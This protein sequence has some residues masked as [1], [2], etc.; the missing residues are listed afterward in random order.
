MKKIILYIGIPIILPFFITSCQKEIILFPFF[1]ND[2][3][4]YL[5]KN[6]KA[7]IAPQYSRSR[8][9]SESFAAVRIGNKW[10]FINDEFTPVI[11]NKYWLVGDFFNGRA[12]VLD[13]DE[14]WT[15]ITSEGKQLS[16]Q[17]FEYVG[18][19]HENFAAVMIDGK[20]GFIDRS[21]KM[22]IS[23]QFS[24]AWPFS[25][26]LAAVNKNGRWF[27]INTDGEPVI[28]NGKFQKVIIENVEDLKS[29]DT[30]TFDDI[31]PFAEGRSRVLIDNQW[32][33][34]D[35]S[36]EMIIPPV[37]RRAQDFSEGLAPVFQDEWFFINPDGEKILI[38]DFN[39][40]WVYPFSEGLAGV[41]LGELFGYINRKGE[42]VI[43]GLFTWAGPFKNGIALVELEGWWGYINKDGKVIWKGKMEN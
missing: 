22:V 4:G 19:F 37:Y 39:P 20:Y 9:F 13:K 11:E 29:S 27:Y 41:L 5:D 16:H 12:W 2:T 17:A 23:P 28:R 7:E 32:G 31:Y 36:G 40:G 30:I 3:W 21:G 18:D 26:R 14:N 42:I 33:F 25:D 8:K 1:E 38:L 6:G 10:G 24:F 15:Y 34:I 43:K 35:K